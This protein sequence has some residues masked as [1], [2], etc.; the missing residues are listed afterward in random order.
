MGAGLVAVAVALSLAVQTAGMPAGGA[1]RRKDRNDRICVI[2]IY[3]DTDLERCV[4][5]NVSVDEVGVLHSRCIESKS[6]KCKLTDG[7][8]GPSVFNFGTQKGGTTSLSTFLHALRQHGAMSVKEL[9]QYDSA[10]TPISADLRHA[11]FERYMSAFPNCT[12]C[13]TSDNTP[14]YMYCGQA[15]PMIRHDWDDSKFIALLR[16]PVSRAISMY[17]MLLEKHGSDMVSFDRLVVDHME[18]FDQ[19]LSLYGGRLNLWEDCMRIDRKMDNLMAK[20]VYAEQIEAYLTY[21]PP[22]RLLVSDSGHF[23]NNVTAPCALKAVT[24]FIGAEVPSPEKLVF[25][26]QNDR[27]A[28]V[29]YSDETVRNAKEFFREKNERLFDFLDYDFGWNDPEFDHRREARYEE[30]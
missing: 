15:L 14:S 29:I 6:I 17:R 26:H 30:V 28:E 2:E 16:E 22:R 11:G 27:H 19:N 4:D 18:D 25:P 23:F 21:F 5:P 7:R 24:Q 8:C 3:P 20:G 10:E 9:H 12:D 1:P 13:F